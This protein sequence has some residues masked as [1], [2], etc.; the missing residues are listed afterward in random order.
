MGIETQWSLGKCI[1]GCDTYIQRFTFTF[2][3]W[4]FITYSSTYMCSPSHQAIT[5]YYLY[6]YLTRLYFDIS[7]SHVKQR[8]HCA[9]KIYTIPLFI[10]LLNTKKLKHG[11][12]A[13]FGRWLS[14]LRELCLCIYT[15]NYWPQYTVHDYAK[16]PDTMH[17]YIRISI[18]VWHV[19][20]VYL[21]NIWPPTQAHI[22]I[23]YFIIDIVPK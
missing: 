14:L 23:Q 21:R 17:T 20:I 12:Y 15:D 19:Y 13:W 2:T 3:N 4:N 11:L 22:I 8:F 6:W 18:S 9:A 1:S 7:I 10:E 5:L 16:T